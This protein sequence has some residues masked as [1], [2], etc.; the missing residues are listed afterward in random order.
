[1]LFGFVWEFFCGGLAFWW[2]FF[3]PFSLPHRRVGAS[4]QRASRSSVLGLN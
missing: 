3:G 1:M 2:G 4:A